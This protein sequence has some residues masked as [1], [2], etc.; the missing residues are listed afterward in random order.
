[1]DLNQIAIITV[2]AWVGWA[3]CG[4]VIWIGK[5]IATMETTLMVHA[6]AVPFIFAG[7]TWF[8]VKWFAYTS[9]FQTAGAFLA[10]V[11]FLDFFVVALLIER[12]LAMFRS[13]MGTWLPFALIFV[14]TYVTGLLS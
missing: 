11:V 12:N 13:V 5:A 9:P 1:M 14:S 3:L 10:V 7:V 2:H 4:A 6:I 8:Y